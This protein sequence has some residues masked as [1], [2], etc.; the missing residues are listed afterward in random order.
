MRKLMAI[1]MLKRMES[2]VN[3]FR[4]TLERIENFIK[5]SIAAINKFEE[6]GAGLIEVTSFA[7]DYDNEDSENDPFVGRKSKINLR[8][9]DYK[10]LEKR[11]ASRLGDSSAHPD[12]VER[13][14]TG[15]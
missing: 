14:Y 6:S 2:S 9:M 4:L 15:T 7:D 3:S 11:F 8:D 5:T 13:Y 1:N 12:H 10:E